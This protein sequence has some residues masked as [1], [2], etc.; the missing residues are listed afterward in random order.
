MIT[1]QK[2]TKPH[3]KSKPHKLNAHHISH[4]IPFPPP[5]IPLHHTTTTSPSIINTHASSA[6]CLSPSNRVGQSKDKPLNTCAYN[7]TNS[8]A[9]DPSPHTTTQRHTIRNDGQHTVIG[10]DHK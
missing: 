2:I 7:F 3:M 6:P 1:Q 9:V 5:T 8:S 4:H 10:E